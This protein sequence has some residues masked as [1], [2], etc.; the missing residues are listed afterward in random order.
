MAAFTYQIIIVIAVLVALPF[1][2][3]WRDRWLLLGVVIGSVV[4]I[5]SLLF[6]L[7][8][9]VVKNK[10]PGLG[11]LDFLLLWLPLVI[12]VIAWY[13]VEKRLKTTK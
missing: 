12:P 8:Y 3:S 4:L 7:S 6:A 10:L 1:Q 5:D 13:Y 9:V 2:V 11:F